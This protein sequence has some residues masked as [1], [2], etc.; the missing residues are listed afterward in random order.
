MKRYKKLLM[1]WTMVLLGAAVFMSSDASAVI[2][3]TAP[4]A[5]V[6]NPFIGPVLPSGI[7]RPPIGLT[8]RVGETTHRIPSGVSETTFLQPLPDSPVF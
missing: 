5:V 1:I 3:G 7:V 2:I 6:G 4:A 8:C